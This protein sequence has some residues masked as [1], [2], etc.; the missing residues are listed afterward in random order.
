MTLSPKIEL[1]YKYT[2]ESP[3]EIINDPIFK[4]INKY[5]EIQQISQYK[6]EKSNQFLFFNSN[7]IHLILYESEELYKVSEN[8]NFSELFYLSLLI[9]QNPETID[10]V[11]SL[12]YIKL[13]YNDFK[14]IEGLKPIKKI[15]LSKIILIL[16]YNYKG[17]DEYNEEEDG[18]YLEMLESQVKEV[19]NENMGIFE[20]LKIECKNKEIYDCKIDNLYIEIILSLIKENK[21]NDF[22]FCKDIIHQLDLENI[23][24]TKSIYEGLYNFFISNDLLL[25]QYSINDL[26]DENIINFYYILIKYIFKNSL[27]IYNIDFLFHNIKNIFK[28][29]KTK[30]EEIKGLLITE[31]SHSQNEINLNDK[32]KEILEFFSKKYSDIFDSILNRLKPYSQSLPSILENKRKENDNGRQIEGIE[33]EISKEEKEEKETN[34]N[35]IDNKIE[36]EK[37]TEILEHLNFKIRIEPSENDENKFKFLEIKYGKLLENELTDEE[38]LKIDADYDFITEEDKKKEK[39]EI[40]YKNYKKLAIFLNA[41]KDYIKVSGIKFNPEIE[42]ELKREENEINEVENAH[43]EIKDLYNITCHYTFVNQINNN[44]QLKFKDENVLVHSIDGKSQGFIHLMNELDNEDY[45][46]AIFEY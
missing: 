12:D 35:I 18:E 39:A 34:N 3:N 16:I 44:E 10:Y 21:F 17:E 22:I 31:S 43:H 15:I 6:K 7:N 38:E 46:D 20:E 29:I 23:N 27:Y 45:S 30:P 2:L 11:Y 13:I 41:I 25:H 4:L 32:I 5:E 14:N 9:S 42:F 1:C 40:V 26:K 33:S 24:I 8:I 19:I 37:A 36:Y 28:I